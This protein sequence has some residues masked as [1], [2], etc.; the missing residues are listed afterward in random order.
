MPS[1][2]VRRREYTVTPGYYDLRCISYVLE[3]FA[4]DDSVMRDGER[5]CA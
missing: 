3:V 2:E 4:V 5:G 1:T